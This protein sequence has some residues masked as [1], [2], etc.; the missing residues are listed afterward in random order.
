MKRWEDAIELLI[1]FEDIFLYFLFDQKL[2]ISL[3]DLKIRSQDIQYRQISH[4]ATKMEA[5]ALKVSEFTMG[6]LI[7]KF[8]NES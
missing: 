1:K 3:L 4:G 8:E 5:T 6:Q 2:T 7:L